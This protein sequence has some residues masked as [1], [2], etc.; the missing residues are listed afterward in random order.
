MAGALWIWYST[1][2]MARVSRAL[3]PHLTHVALWT[4][5]VERS[6][7]FYRKHCDLEVVHDRVEPYGGRVVW[8]GESADR[9]RFVIVLIQRPV[10]HS[11][12]NSFAHFGFSCASRKDVDE[13]AAV[14]R[15]DGVLELEPRDAGAVVGYF[16]M[17]RDP[18]GNSV[19]FSFGQA[20]GL[21]PAHAPR[22]RKARRSLT[23]RGS[24][25]G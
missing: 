1:V 18:D 3:R 6:V 10:E 4:S 11:A 2:P 7:D 22:R 20:L 24:R 19:E 17:L 16:C 23:Q 9:S 8:V 13:R 25:A 12:P 5:E 21:P 15:A 14:A